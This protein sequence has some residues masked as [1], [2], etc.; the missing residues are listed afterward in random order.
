MNCIQL[1]I[2]KK[3]KKKLKQT[4]ATQS[5]FSLL[6]LMIVLAL[7]GLLGAFVVPNLFRAKQGAQQKEFLSS[8][9]ALLKDA[10]LRSIVENKMHQ[11]FI[12]IAHELIQ[13]R[14][15]DAQSIES[16]KHK[17]FARVL[18]SDYLT[19]IKFPK[20][21]AMKDFFINGVQEFAPGTAAL[22]VMFYVMPD[23]TSQAI[24]ANIIDQDEDSIEPEVTFSFVINPFYA[25][26]SVHETFQTP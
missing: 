10:V 13:T 21:F 6:E 14:A 4:R 20:R 17:K 11:I 25:R 26:M 9:E 24:I 16:N 2:Q 5:G 18:D 1:A 15:Y 12:D 22:D 7:I 23:G 8:F 3:K 19:E